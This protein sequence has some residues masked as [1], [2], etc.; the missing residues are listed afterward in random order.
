MSY[1]LSLRVSQVMLLE[2]GV[3]PDSDKVA[4][5][6]IGREQAL[7]IK[8]PC[9]SAPIQIASEQRPSNSSHLKR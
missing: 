6:L 8:R 5:R 9:N 3:V 4:T 2:W 7:L 1:H